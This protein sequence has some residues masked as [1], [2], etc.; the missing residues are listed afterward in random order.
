MN[1][2]DMTYHFKVN[3]FRK[4]FDDFNNG[5]KLFWKIKSGKFKLENANNKQTKKQKNVDRMCLNQI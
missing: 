2:S 1:Q 3:T 4:R 5:I